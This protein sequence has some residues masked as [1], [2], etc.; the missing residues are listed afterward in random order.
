M[1]EAAAR[2]AAG[3]PEIEVALIAAENLTAADI[4]AAD[5][6]IFA[7]P[8]NLG[9]LSGAMKEA[10]DR[11]Y[12]DVIDKVSGRP[13]AQMIA[14]GSDGTGAARQL[15][16]IVAGWRLKVV[17]EPLIVCTDAQTPEAI[18]AAK[19]LTEHDLAPCFECGAALAVGLNLGIF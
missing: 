5:G 14:A 6:Y 18:N 4:L 16:R 3:E 17:A 10:F 7:A 19:H 11:T 8:E 12:Y 2:G 13:Y 15:A 1:A 9:T